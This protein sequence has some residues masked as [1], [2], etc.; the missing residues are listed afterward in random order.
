[1]DDLHRSQALHETRLLSDLTGAGGVAS[2]AGGKPLG[3]PEPSDPRPTSISVWDA[4]D[5]WN[6]AIAHEI[7]GPSAAGRPVYLDIEEDVLAAVA[8]HAEVGEGDA[9]A[10]ADAVGAT[11]WLHPEGQNVFQG[12]LTRLLRWRADP[13]QTPPTLA[14]LAVL[15]LAAESMRHGEGMSANNYYG[16]LQEIL[17]VTDER[18][19][20]K[21]IRDYRAHAVTLWS[22]LNE[23]LEEWEGQRGLPTA[24]AVTFPYIGLA[25]SQALVRT[26]DRRR[27]RSFFAAAG[28]SPGYSVALPVMQR[29]LDGWISQ[30]PPPVSNSLRSLW[31]RD[32]TAQERIAGVACIE[33]EAWDGTTSPASG[34][35]ASRGELRLVALVRK[36]L[37]VQLELSLAARVPDGA[38]ARRFQPMG[39]VPEGAQT[40]TGP[41]AV[42]F[43]PVGDGWLRLDDPTLVDP[44]SMLGATVRLASQ[45]SPLTLERV[46]RRVVPLRRDES[47]QMFVESDRVQLGEDALLLCR[48]DI[49]DRVEHA[50]QTAARPGFTRH[51]R[52]TGGLPDGWVLF[53]DVEMLAAPE[54]ALLAAADLSALE[55]A[56]WSQLLL[57]GGLQLPGRIR[58]WE[59]LLPPEVRAMSSTADSVRVV[60]ECRRPLNG[61]AP[62]PITA[63]SATAALVLPLAPYSLPD[64][65]Y[66]V[67]LLEGA[68]Q[69][70]S[71]HATLRLRSADT[72]PEAWDEPPPLVY[73][74]GAA[75]GLGVIS[76]GEPRPEATIV[77]G[78]QT[79]VA[80]L[81]ALPPL[82]DQPLQDAP[83]W[84][85]ARSTRPPVQQPTAPTVVLGQED[86]ASC[87]VTGA[88][89]MELPADTGRRT[90]PMFS[91][92]CRDC[93]VVKWYPSW[94]RRQ[95][96]TARRDA[97]QHRPLD[98]RGITPIPTTQAIPWDTA[99]DALCHLGWGTA[100]EFERIALQLDGSSLLADMLTR[101][102]EALG[103]IDVARD[104]HSLRPARWRVAPTMLAGL[105]SGEYVLVG[106]RSERLLS[107]LEAC[108]QTRGGT[109]AQE[110]ESNGP[111]TVILRALKPAAVE[112]VTRSIV[113]FDG[114]EPDVVHAAAARMAAALPP[115][116]SLLDALPH[117]SLPHT[118]AL[119]RWD[120]QTAEWRPATLAD[121]PGAYKLRSP[122]VLYGIRTGQDLADGTLR[123]ATAQAVKHLA[124]LLDDTVHAAYHAK[125]SS[126]LVPLG[127]DLPGLYG[128]AAVLCSGRLPTRLLT[129]PLLCYHDVPREIAGVIVHALSH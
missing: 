107:E 117:V 122:L 35:T 50:L 1:V 4:Y 7:F 24:F 52:G 82:A 2:Q 112:A 60:V 119:E 62:E 79:F 47:L 11:L 81:E 54:P 36:L 27:L 115:A 13:R 29:L 126:L 95:R 58:K 18:V 91:G 80:P 53:S 74:L 108:V 102:L 3:R 109:L 48:D 14:L 75:A 19:A 72:P 45:G 23:W 40:A 83:A 10:L 86:R 61:H 55:P 118:D 64:G 32:K 43:E 114:T 104:S 121:R 76:A 9:K 100:S 5:R 116:R 22:S 90:S 113:D 39:G 46:P 37:G 101:A 87:G 56:T 110:Q 93:G 8:R 59:S 71:M 96:R 73:L 124:A 15:S 89:F 57:G 31:R 12:H 67:A 94:P 41:A 127:A 103:H 34:A 68:N 85:Q 128:R 78:A 6:E 111:S 88:H 105:P 20:T 66:Q 44:H 84:L 51:G 16:R 125:T 65:D 106:R 30:E 42:G 120:S 92:R 49:A 97:W 28:L 63:N 21:L 70:A 33:L 99:L 26:A 129:S 17:D 69:A 38:A 77:R 25:I 123:V 98:T